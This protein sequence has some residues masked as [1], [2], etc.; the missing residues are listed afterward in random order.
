[1][2]K[3]EILV[4]S[5]IVFLII[6]VA[7]AANVKWTALT[8]LTTPD[9]NDFLCIVDDPCGSPVSKKI[10]RNNLV[11]NWTGSANITTLGTIATGTWQGTVIDHERGGLEADI[12]AYSGLIAVSGG[13]TSEVD[14]LSELIGQL[15]DV[16]AFITD[17]DMP[18]AATDPDIDAAGEIGRD[19]DGGNEPNS[20]TLRITNA[21]GNLQYVLANTDKTI[22]IPI[23]EPDALAQGDYFPVWTNQSGFT[24]HITEIG[25]ESD[26]DD[27]DFTLKERDADGGNVTTIEA[28]QLTT[29]G[30]SMYYGT[31]VEADIDH[32]L[33]ETGHSIGYDNSADDA[34][35]VILWIKGYY[36]ADVD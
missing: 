17:D 9:V 14:A 2:R 22:K 33:I 7:Y 5:I 11:G 25:G 6:T 8:E 12:N 21:S 34:T 28:V 36:D 1:M 35:Y 19:T 26:I 31:V 16:T 13:A 27:F 32:K 20:V 10:T 24:F 15:A 18:A 29:D 30:T 4:I 3:K 23:A